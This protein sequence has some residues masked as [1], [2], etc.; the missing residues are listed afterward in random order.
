[1]IRPWSVPE[2]EALKAIPPLARGMLPKLAH[3]WGRSYRSVCVKRQRLIG[4]VV[5]HRR[6]TAKEDKRL[7]ELRAAGLLHREIALV[8]GRTRFSIRERLLALR[9]RAS[10]EKM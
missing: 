10:V 3:E 9:Q 7:V 4:P 2:E 8:L 5:A 1:M 6:W